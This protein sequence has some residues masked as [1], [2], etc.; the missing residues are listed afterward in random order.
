MSDIHSLDRTTHYS[1]QRRRR[2][3]TDRHKVRPNKP[4]PLP[5]LIEMVEDEDPRYRS[6]RMSELLERKLNLQYR[7]LDLM[8]ELVRIESK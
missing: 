7:L 5:P 8:S 6:D 3:Q 2:A 4:L 1:R